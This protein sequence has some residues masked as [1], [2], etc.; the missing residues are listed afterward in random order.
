M[1]EI[2][3][4]PVTF[5]AMAELARHNIV[6]QLLDDWSESEEEEEAEQD[7]RLWMKP[8]LQAR[9]D[10]RKENIYKEIEALDETKFHQCFRMPP[11]VF[12]KLLEMVGP[13]ITKQTTQLRQ[14]ISAKIRL[15]VCL[16]YLASGA[17]FSVLEDI[18]RISKVTISKIIPEVCTAIW[19]ILGPQYIVCPTTAEGWL[20]KADRFQELWQYPRALDGKHVQVAAFGNSGSSF[21]NYKGTFSIVL[22]AITDADSRFLFVDI[23]HP[24]AANDSGIFRKTCFYQ[25]LQ[26]E[27]LNLPAMPE[28]LKVLHHFVAD[29]AFGLSERI[30]KPFPERGLDLRQRIFNY[31]FSRARRI[32]EGSFGLMSAKFRILRTPLLQNYQHAKKTVQAACVLHNYLLKEGKQAY[33]TVAAEE[34]SQAVDGGMMALAQQAGNRSGNTTAREQR[35]L[36]ATH[37][38]MEGAVDWQWHQVL[39][40]E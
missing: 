10:P 31:R 1:W 28:G 32:V 11:A 13:A 16:R 29:D 36:L 37:F 34:R 14:P 27:D 4:Y 19:E 39:R 17:N 18:F 25:A 3:H 38:V 22:M 30:Y 20:E 7:K 8:W 6:C 2:A 23:G 5:T 12:D 35:D 33:S 24:G 21:R 40:Q 15:Q 26:N 9:D